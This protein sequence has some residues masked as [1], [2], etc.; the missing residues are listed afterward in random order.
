MKTTTDETSA[1]A[2]S[3]ETPDDYETFLRHFTPVQH[4]VQVYVRAMVFDGS[5]ANDVF[6]EA[7]LAMWK[8]Y[9]TFVRQGDFQSWALGIARLQV[10]KYWRTRKRDRHIFTLPMLDSLTEQA[11]DLVS[12]I[13]PRQVALNAC[14]SQLSRRH[15]GLIQN[16]Y[17][18]GLPAE[19]IAESW[20][21]SVHAVYKALRVVRQSLLE[22]VQQKLARKQ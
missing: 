12:E 2:R 10:L 5:A 3:S 11:R 9:S 17:A 19:A 16:F 21:R 8:N 4:R 18:Q 6:Q 22:C 13:D 1:E 7:C 15:K 14:V 20:D